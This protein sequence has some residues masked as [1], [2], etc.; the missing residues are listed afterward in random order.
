[1]VVFS[2]KGRE[3]APVT[4][5]T[6]EFQSVDVKKEGLVLAFVRK[7]KAPAERRFKPELLLFLYI[8][9]IFFPVAKASSAPY[10]VCREKHSGPQ[11]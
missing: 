4:Q 7:C 6:A 3:I 10:A 11:E 2:A 9:T 5:W 1:M 8:E